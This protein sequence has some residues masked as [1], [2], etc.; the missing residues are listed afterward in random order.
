MPGWLA[1]ISQVGCW[2]A[3]GAGLS[4]AM[5]MADPVCRYVLRGARCRR[6]GPHRCT[7]R[8]GHVVAFFGEILTH[9]KGAFARQPFIPRPGKGIGCW[10]HCL[11][12]SFTTPSVA[13]MCRKYRVLYLYLPRK[14]GKSELLAGIVLYLLC[15]DGEVGVEIHGLALDQEQAGLVYRVAR[16][17]VRNSAELTDRLTVVRSSGRIVDESTGSLYAIVAGDAPGSLGFDPSGAYIDELL[18]QPSRELYYAIRT[19]FGSRAEPLLLLA[20]T[21][22]NDPA[23]FA[24]SEREWSTRVL[25]DP[26]LDPERLVVMFTAPDG[27]DWTQQATWRAANPALGD[28]LEVRV[29]ASECRQAQGNP[30]AERSF[31]QYRL[32][33]PA[34]KVGRAIDLATWDAS[35]GPLSVPQMAAELARQPCWA[36]LDLASTSD[37]AAYALNFPQADGSQAILWRHFA[38]SSALR[39]LSRRTGGKADAWVA[40]GLLTLTPGNV[41]D[42][43][44]ITKALGDDRELYDIREV[45]FDRWG[46]TQLSSQLLD[47]GWP[48]IQMG[49]GYASMAAPTSELL[50]LIKAG[51]YHH[52]GN[53][54]ARWEAGNCVTRADPAGNLKLDKQRS[55]DKIDGLVAGVMALDRAQRAA[56]M[57]AD[58]YVAAGW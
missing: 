6:R 14:N 12:M 48:L 45:A 15:A 46:A 21:A 22:E 1:G 24:A 11:A 7:G 10:P 52:G 19:S 17:M 29:L 42:Y 8:V 58:D 44:A 34:N 57:P 28:F 30:A 16:Q 38:P 2:A 37:L 13:G 35:A 39:E 40:A 32:N 9:T 53:P 3:W 5:T 18:T 26:S 20:T 27:A 25:D 56:L 55:A 33:Q 4:R 47:E 36:G 31:R 54:V 49:Q 50:R 23:G 41:I 51:L 43:G